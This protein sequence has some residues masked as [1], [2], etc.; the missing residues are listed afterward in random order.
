MGQLHRSPTII[1]TQS[2][3]SINEHYIE[4]LSGFSEYFVRRE[5]F[6]YSIYSPYL[7]EHVN[8]LHWVG[9]GLWLSVGGPG[10]RGVADPDTFF[11]EILGV[12]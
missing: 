5:G 10:G 11:E 3:I 6:C 12:R 2:D 7:N 1:P 9:E 4:V 8:I